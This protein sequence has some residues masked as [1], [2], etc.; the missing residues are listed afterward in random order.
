MIGWI[1]VVAVAAVGGEREAGQA[2]PEVPVDD[3][4]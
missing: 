2:G 4:G 3:E 1:T